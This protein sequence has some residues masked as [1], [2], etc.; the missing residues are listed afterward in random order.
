MIDYLVKYFEQ[1][2]SPNLLQILGRA[3]QISTSRLGELKLKEVEFAIEPDT[4]GIYWAAF[5]R[6][7]EIVLRG[8]EET[9]KQFMTLK[10]IL[11]KNS[12]IRYRLKEMFN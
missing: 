12:G 2:N 4:R 11:L 3:E 1:L 8:E 7:D 9:Q 6:L 5:D 10:R